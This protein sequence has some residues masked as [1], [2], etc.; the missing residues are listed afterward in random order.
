MAAA[1]DKHVVIIQYKPGKFPDNS[2]IN[3]GENGVIMSV[4]HIRD[5]DKKTE[6]PVKGCI[7]FSI[8]NVGT[9]KALLFDGA[10]EILPGQ[11]WFPQ[12]STHLPLINQPTLTFEGD[13][14]LSRSIADVILPTPEA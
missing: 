8:T 5:I 14:Q 1:L 4:E 12:K 6:I 10:I 7:D 2:A 13:V 9:A 3:P 11:T